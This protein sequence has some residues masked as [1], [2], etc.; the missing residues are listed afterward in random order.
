M[1]KKTNTVLCPECGKKVQTDVKTIE[2][3]IRMHWGVSL[4]QIETI[5]NSVAKMRALGLFTSIKGG[6]K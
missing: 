6:K 5:K 2:K 4:A 3:H 1:G